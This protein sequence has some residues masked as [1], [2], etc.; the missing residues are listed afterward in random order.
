MNMKSL[1]FRWISPCLSV[2]Q[3]VFRINVQ[4]IWIKPPRYYRVEF[5][6]GPEF[7][8]QTL[9]ILWNSIDKT[10]KC[11]PFSCQMSCI[12]DEYFIDCD[13][14]EYH[15]HFSVQNWSSAL[16]TEIHVMPLATFKW[17]WHGVGGVS[18]SYQPSFSSGV[19]VTLDRW[20]ECHSNVHHEKYRVFSRSSV[21]KFC[22]LPSSKV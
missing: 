4:K 22:I 19:T 20:N 11:S 12:W 13:R 8:C 18:C 5:H 17:L 16:Q 14:L 21:S 9:Q 15:N 1:S 7:A 2:Q 3:A 6:E 10:A